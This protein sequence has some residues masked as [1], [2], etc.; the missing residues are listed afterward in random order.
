M[1]NRMVLAAITLVALTGSVY[2]QA[3]RDSNM[4]DAAQSGNASATGRPNTTVG[5]S[6]SPTAMTPSGAR[7]TNGADGGAPTGSGMPGARNSN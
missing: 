5:R 7:G 1:K 3:A 2:A 6:T 4:T